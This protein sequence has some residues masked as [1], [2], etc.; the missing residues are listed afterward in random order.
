LNDASPQEFF[1]RAFLFW[2]CL[3]LHRPLQAQGFQDIL[4]H[5]PNILALASHAPEHQHS[6]ENTMKHIAPCVFAGRPFLLALL[7]F[8]VCQHVIAQSQERPQMPEVTA[9]LHA[10]G[11][12]VWQRVSPTPQKPDGPVL[13]QLL[14]STG[15]TPGTIAK[16]DINPRHLTN[17][18]ITDNGGIVAI[19]GS[20]F[21]INAGTGLVT[22]ANGQI[23]PG[24]GTV[25]S[26]SAASPLSV[27]NGGTTPNIALN[28]I[29]GLANG[30]TG[31]SSAGSAGSFLRSNGTAWTV[32]SIQ[33]GD[34]PS[35]SGSYV[36]LATDQTIGG[37]KT[38]SNL[39][40]TGG[41]NGT[42]ASFSGTTSFGGDLTVGSNGG[43]VIVK[44]AVAVLAPNNT[45]GTT[46]NELA[47]ISAAG[48]G[49]VNTAGTSNSVGTIGIVVAGA[50][51]SG[52]SGL[53]TVAVTG[54]VPCS[55]DGPATAADYVVKSTTTGGMCR[56]GGTNYP[57][58]AQT[59]GRVIGS[60]DPA[61]VAPNCITLVALYPGEQRGT[62][63]AG[64]DLSGTLANATVAGLQGNPLSTASPVTGQV[65][66]FDGASWA[67][68]A[69][70]G[71]GTV[72]SVS[73]TD[74]FLTINS[75]TTTPVINFNTANTDARYVLKAGD[76]MAGTLQA[77]ELIVRNDF[78]GGVGA[79]LQITNGAGG[80][81]TGT[82]I[83]FR[84]Y[85][86]GNAAPEA[87]I[88]ATDDGNA[89]NTVQ[90][91]TKANGSTGN[92]L[93]SRVAIGSAGMTVAGGVSATGPVA[94]GGGYTQPGSNETLRIVRGL[95]N[96]DGTIAAGAGFTVQVLVPGEVIIHITPAFSATPAVT[97]S[98]VPVVPSTISNTASV[99]AEP[100]DISNASFLVIT[101]DATTPVGSV[102]AE[103]FSFIAI[104]PP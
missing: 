62:P 29:V 91:L 98:P 64:G 75:P 22:F 104:G 45:V 21:M 5:P 81:G 73:N 36:D 95:V 26:V 77:P 96:A 50:G 24:T 38:F 16:F 68:S 11:N 103:A 57:T 28:G 53:A 67:P 9:S 78:L 33:F 3:R 4:R 83:D 88:A 34:L 100:A 49:T 58:G 19:G 54:T 86:V 101:R 18:D 72:T 97:M 51:T 20:G 79:T 61:C 12:L 44:N 82:A 2:L 89:S 59:V 93:V 35:L 43:N 69:I 10:R 63:N 7:V 99:F 90:I 14:F 39:F 60:T 42:T 84:S 47:E 70:S 92:N 71:T 8:G 55:F 27:T 13:Y 48:N 56:D 40:I 46:L 32:S 66:R 85:T 31:L 74:N 52:S 80:A 87:R 17:S 41:L 6:T 30:G 94:A 25:T 76:T 23:F 15:G 65:L 1:L 37:N 102:N